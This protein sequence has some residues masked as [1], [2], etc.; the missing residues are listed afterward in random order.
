MFDGAGA[1]TV[2]DVNGVTV[3]YTAD[4]IKNY[5][6]LI[7]YKNYHTTVNK[8]NRTKYDAINVAA[9][10]DDFIDNRVLH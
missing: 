1:D 7:A 2:R 10:F 3:S 8:K 6:Y 9:E 5:L 4:E